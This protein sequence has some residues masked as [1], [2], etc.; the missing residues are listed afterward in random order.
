[1]TSFNWYPKNNN[2]R[3]HHH[4]TSTYCN[5]PFTSTAE[6]QLRFLCPSDL[7]QV[8]ELC[9]EWFPIQYPDTWY[10]DITSDPRFYSLAAIYQSQLVGLLIAEV[11]NS[12]AI[13]KEDRGILDTRM[14]KNC[15][16]G[17]ILSLGVCSSL[18][19]QGVASLLLDSFLNHV[20]QTENQICKAIYLHVLTMNSA[21]IRFYEKHYFRL[22]SFLPYY[23]SVDGKCK[24]GFSYVLY[25]NGGHPPWGLLD[26][27]YNWCQSLYDN[28]Y[29]SYWYNKVKHWLQN[30]L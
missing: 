2:S 7:E 10:R 19:R 30:H 28:I 5:A 18:R 15:H 23:Y 9:N 25:I 6:L 12:D 8:K 22:H 24:D 21:A 16:V 4:D 20:T 13:N 27:L 17:Y 29:P 1:M 11:K 26:Y 3:E 14:Y